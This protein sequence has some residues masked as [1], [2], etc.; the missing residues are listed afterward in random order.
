MFQGCHWF[1]EV[2][3]VSNC[4][5]FVVGVSRR[6]RVP[7]LVDL[8]LDLIYPNTEGKGFLQYLTICIRIRYGVDDCW[9]DGVMMTSGCYELCAFLNV[10]LH[11][12]MC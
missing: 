11:A 12:I 7:E 9:F 6:S 5:F 8:D 3:L 10:K 2:R 4:L 1:S